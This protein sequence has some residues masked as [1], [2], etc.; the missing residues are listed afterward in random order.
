[1]SASSQQSGAYVLM[2]AAYNEEAF[3]EGTIQSVLAQTVRPRRWVIVSDNSSDRTDEIVEGY[4][5]Q[6]DFIRLLRITRAP[7]HSFGAKVIALQAG[8]KLLQDAEYEFIG[9]LDADISLGPTYFEELI[10][11]FRQNPEIGLVGGFV[12]EESDGEYRSRRVNDVRNVAHAAQLVRRE[13]YEAIGGYTVL[14]YGGE[15]WYAQTTARMMGWQ[16]EAFPNLKIFHHRHTGGGSNWMKSA[17]RLGALDYSFGSDLAF[18]VMKCLRRVPDK[19]YFAVAFARLAGFV[20]P[21]LRNEA[22]GVPEEFV[23][24]LRREQRGRLSALLNRRRSVDAIAPRVSVA[25]KGASNGAKQ[26]ES[27]FQD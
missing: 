10:D 21:Y 3:I 15:D 1:M 27:T 8:S 23:S 13:C 2:T 7:G 12:Y 17:L 25:S 4:A 9:N 14:K 19:P 26:T 22:R 6:H 24:Y 11:R 16:V 5:R 20:W 18:E